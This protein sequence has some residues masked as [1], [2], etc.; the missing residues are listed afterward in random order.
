LLLYYFKSGRR[1]NKFIHILLFFKNTVGA[2]SFI[3]KEKKNYNLRYIKLTRTAPRIPNTTQRRQKQLPRETSGGHTSQRSPMITPISEQTTRTLR[4]GQQARRAN[5]RLHSHRQHSK[6]TTEK[7][8]RTE[9]TQDT[10]AEHS[11]SRTETGEKKPKCALDAIRNSRDRARQ[12]QQKS[13]S[14][15]ENADRQIS[16]QEQR[17]KEPR[18]RLNVGSECLVAGG[19]A[20]KE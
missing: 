14:Q 10:A 1:G 2:L 11:N 8:K 9:P 12:Q 4:Q 7:K 18:I 16:S 3:K 20:S 19:T 5:T 15:Q 6:P 17:L 13:T